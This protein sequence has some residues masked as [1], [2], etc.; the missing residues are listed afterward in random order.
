MLAVMVMAEASEGNM[1]VSISPARV[2]VSLK[3][4]EI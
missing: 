1:K 4:I 3:T 2:V